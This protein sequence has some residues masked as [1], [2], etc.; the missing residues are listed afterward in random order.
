MTAPPRRIPSSRPT[1]SNRQP[2][3]R[4]RRRQTL[5]PYRRVLPSLMPLNR[6]LQPSRSMRPEPRPNTVPTRCVPGPTRQR[7]RQLRPTQPLPNRRWPAPMLP[8]APAQ[9]RHP[10]PGLSSRPRRPHPRPHPW[11]RACQWRPTPMQ[12]FRPSRWL[13]PRRRHLLKPR[14]HRQL[15]PWQNR[16]RR[17]RS[18]VRHW[19]RLRV[20][21]LLFLP[22]PGLRVPSWRC[23]I[24]PIASL[25]SGLPR[26][27]RSV[28]AYPNGCRRRS[29][30]TIARPRPRPIPPASANLRLL[31]CPLHPPADIAVP[32][33]MWRQYQATSSQISTRCLVRR[34]AALPR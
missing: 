30:P 6:P 20:P 3:T 2:R 27:R 16:P 11:P 25:A 33:R 13:P 17:P 26:H 5:R 23:S 21:S 10:P 29:W 7:P 34:W 31:L 9:T 8:Q 14:R 19:R 15:R 24:P 4:I 32:P 12:P 18:P 22:F 1:A 28:R